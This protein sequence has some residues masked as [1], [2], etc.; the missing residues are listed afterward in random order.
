MDDPL[1]VDVLQSSSR[2]KADHENLRWRQQVPG[3]HHPQQTPALHVVAH[4]VET[5]VGISPVVGGHH[6]GMAYR[7][8]FLGGLQEA[9]DKCPFPNPSVGQDVLG[10]QFDRYSTRLG[11]VVGEIHVGEPAGANV[12]YE[13]ITPAQNSAD[14]A[15]V[16]GHALRVLA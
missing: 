6:M 10:E 7:G 1:V 15:A 3:I 2:V 16:I 9:A 12:G 11:Q 14:L 8:G 5:E 4:H 13:P